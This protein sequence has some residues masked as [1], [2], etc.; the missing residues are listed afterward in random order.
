MH[1]I[2]IELSV[3]DAKELWN[4]LNQTDWNDDDEQAVRWMKA[5][6]AAVEPGK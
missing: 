3:E 2:Y 4:Y 1:T 6:R 5:I